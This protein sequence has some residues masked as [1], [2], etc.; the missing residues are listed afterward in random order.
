MKDVLRGQHG[1]LIARAIELGRFATRSSNDWR[2]SD[3]DHPSP[4]GAE[5]RKKLRDKSSKAAAAMRSAAVEL[6]AAEQAVTDA[7]QESDATF[8]SRCRERDVKLRAA[9]EAA[10]AAPATA[11]KLFDEEMERGRPAEG[12]AG[13]VAKVGRRRFA[14]LLSGLVQPLLN[15]V[16]GDV[17]SEWL[18]RRAAKLSQQLTSFKDVVAPYCEALARLSPDGGRRIGRWCKASWIDVLGAVVGDLLKAIDAGDQGL[19]ISAVEALQTEQLQVDVAIELAKVRGMGSDKA[20][21]GASA[22][23]GWGPAE[24]FAVVCDVIL[25]GKRA[26]GKSAVV[27]AGDFAMRIAIMDQVRSRD[28]QKLPLNKARQYLTPKGRLSELN[29]IYREG[30]RVIVTE[31][32]AERWAAHQQGT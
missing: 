9:K 19:L 23:D 17:A 29:W 14:V 26:S 22:L 28:L 21:P 20:N 8:E 31:V 25:S 18:R 6:R 24:T 7:L 2:T 12:G 4:I 11:V 16:E 32:G 10:A 27:H 5:A 30:D 13:D 3:L 15:Q 1:D